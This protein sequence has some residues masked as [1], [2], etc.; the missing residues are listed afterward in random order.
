MRYVQLLVGLLSIISRPVHVH[1]APLTALTVFEQLGQIPQGWEQKSTV[2]ASKRLHFRIALKN[3]KAFEF[4]QH[5]IDIST[6]S[7]PKYGQH[8]SHEELKRAL[9]PS[10]DATESI[11]GWLQAEGVS[12]TNIQDDGDWI[13][14]YVSAAEAETMMDT[15]SVTWASD[16]PLLTDMMWQVLLLH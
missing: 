13:N 5:V 3:E 1:A 10:S 11:M 15:K 8:M 6:P 9:R 14:F 4:E 7:H 2:P 16:L 12:A